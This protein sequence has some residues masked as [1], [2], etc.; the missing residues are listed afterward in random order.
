MTS[1]IFEKAFNNT[2]NN[3]IP[4]RTEQ[5]YFDFITDTPYCSA[6]AFYKKNNL[7]PLNSNL[8]DN[9][10]AL[11]ILAKKIFCN[12]FNLT[13][14]LISGRHR[15]LIFYDEENQYIVFMDP[16]LLHKAPII[17]NDI[18]NEPYRAFRYEVLP[19]G[20]NNYMELTY[21]HNENKILQLKKIFN[22]EI[23]FEYNLNDILLNDPYPYDDKLLYHNEQDNLSIR[24]L[25]KSKLY[26]LHLVCSLKNVISNYLKTGNISYKLYTISNRVISNNNFDT[27]N[28]D[29]NLISTIVKMHPEDVLEF[30]NNSIYSYLSN[31]P[32]LYTFDR[33]GHY[34]PS[35]L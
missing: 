29:L 18:L 35:N 22:S 13:G 11:S 3:K 16:Y 5:N 32:K 2:K 14:Y 12:N 9:C 23:R 28:N 7:I 10:I 26:T 17:L 24:V 27:F 4:S 30:M 15:P 19:D 33:V 6:V 31:L 8:G 1:K 34:N 21:F 20:P 25:H